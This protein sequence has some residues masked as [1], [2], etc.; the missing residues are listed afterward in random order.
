MKKNTT[1]KINIVID[2]ELKMQFNIKCIKNGTDMSKVLKSFIKEYIR[3]T[4]LDIDEET[5]ESI[6]NSF[7]G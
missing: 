2:S 4:E 5:E 3:D 6:Y 7:M 1:D